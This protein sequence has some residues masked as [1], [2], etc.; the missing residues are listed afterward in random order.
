MTDTAFASL[1]PSM[2]ATLV[3]ARQDQ[4]AAGRAYDIAEEA[5]TCGRGCSCPAKPT[6][7]AAWNAWQEAGARRAER[8]AAWNAYCAIRNES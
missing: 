7:S 4:V 3:R 5:C 1:G 6:V 8:E 2:H